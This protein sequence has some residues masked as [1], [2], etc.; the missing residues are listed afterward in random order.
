[1]STL[2]AGL[3]NYRVPDHITL[4]HVVKFSGGRSSG[5][6]TLSLARGGVLQPDR[7]DVVLFANTTAEHPA[8]YEFAARVCDEV[9]SEHG[10]P[11]FW[12]E[13]CTVEMASADGYRRRSSYQLVK[14]E[15]R[16]ATD[17]DAVQGYRSDGSAFEELASFKAMLP[18]RYLRICTRFLKVLPGIMLLSEWYGG[19][20]G[21]AHAGHGHGRALVGVEDAVRRYKGT[22]LTSEEYADVVGFVHSRRPARPAQVWRSF[23]TARLDRPVE[24]PRPVADLWGRTGPPF[25]Y[26]TLLG[27]RAD[28]EKRVQRMEMQNLFAEGA[29]SSRCKDT[30]QP[31]GE[32]VYAPLADHG[33]ATRD[34]E[35]FWNRQAFDL[36]IDSSL[37]NCVF[38]FMK[39]PRA[40]SRI[41]RS[42]CTPP[43]TGTPVSIDWWADIETK[44][45]R[46]S[47]VDEGSKFKFLSLKSLSF[48][49]LANGVRPA[50]SNGSPSVPCAC[51]D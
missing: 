31:P 25:R 19:G 8:T 40:L 3:P 51:T 26:V 36:G 42:E 10:V 35:E 39:G 43:N 48:A 24:G 20:P 12:Y 5:A 34:V 41:A 9:E 2:L 30:S 23:T 28:E 49:D 1:M 16:Q 7:G 29:G 45:G 32:L 15:P 11:C 33:A 37:G 14:R 47:T 18:N 21:P 13:F 50:V 27:L 46:E 22:K 6:M 4:P 17:D 38:C 44:Y